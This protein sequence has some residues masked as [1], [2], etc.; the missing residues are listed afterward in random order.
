VFKYRFSTL[1]N[2]DFSFIRHLRS[3]FEI[4]DR[5]AALENLGTDVDINRAWK[6]N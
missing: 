5:F 1:L 2:S 4:S 6:T 3:D